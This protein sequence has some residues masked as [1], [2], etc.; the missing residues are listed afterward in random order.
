MGE[1][2]HSLFG[3]FDNFG[4]CIITYIAPCYTF[5]KNAEAVGD[6]CLLCGAAWL[7][8]ILNIVAWIQVRGKIRD[9]HKIDGSLLGDLLQIVCCTVCALVQEAQEVQNAPSSV[10]IVRE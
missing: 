7:V 10:G 3:C 2:K 4:I 6:S 1:W 5:G 8:P 9:L